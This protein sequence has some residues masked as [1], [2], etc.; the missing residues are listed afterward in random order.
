V[1]ALRDG[2]AHPPDP[3]ERRGEIRMFIKTINS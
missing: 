3:G 1:A 2:P